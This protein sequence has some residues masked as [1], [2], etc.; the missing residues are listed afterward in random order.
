MEISVDI[1]ALS[2]VHDRASFV[3]SN[4]FLNFYLK[5]QVNQDDR[6]NLA[7]CFVAVDNDRSKD[8]IPGKKRIAGFL[9]FLQAGYQVIFFLKALPGDYHIP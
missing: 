8:K 1:E 4:E 5:Q 7:N 6:K 3:C 2:K 9:R